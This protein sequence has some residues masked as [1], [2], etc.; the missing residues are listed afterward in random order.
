MSNVCVPV[1]ESKI[2]VFT[3]RKSGS[4]N[5]TC[6]KI[7]SFGIIFQDLKWFKFCTQMT[8][9]TNVPLKFW[10]LNLNRFHA[11]IVWKIDSYALS[12]TNMLILCVLR[13]VYPSW[14]TSLASERIRSQRLWAH[15]APIWPPEEEVM[16]ESLIVA[17]WNRMSVGTPALPCD[18]HVETKSDAGCE[19][20]R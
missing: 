13:S 17:A 7:F 2:S 19:W 1:P 18:C 16:R 14:H 20:S 8:T 3:R 10:P 11:C 5:L 9:N 15:K 4:F 6:T 12:T